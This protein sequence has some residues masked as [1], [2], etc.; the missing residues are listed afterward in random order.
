[1]EKTSENQKEV[2]AF[3]IV[4]Q[5]PHCVLQNLLAC[6]FVNRGKTGESKPSMSSTPK[7]LGSREQIKS[8]IFFS[9]H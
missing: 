5:E 4:Q 1:M 8:L 2:G 9:S 7:H 6:G 3:L